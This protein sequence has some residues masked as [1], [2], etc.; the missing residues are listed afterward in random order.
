MSQYSNPLELD[1]MKSIMLGVVILTSVIPCAWANS[2][3]DYEKQLMLRL[4]ADR[5]PGGAVWLGSGRN[6]FLSLYRE[7]TDL[8]SKNAAIILHSMG[9][10]ADWPDLISPLRKHLPETGWTSLSVQ[11]PVLSPEIGIA[12]YGGTFI[13]ANRRIRMAVRY[14][15]DKDYS[16]IVFIGVG[17]GATTAV[18]YLTTSGSAVKALVGI[19][20]QNHDFLKPKYN[21]V[22]NLS[23]IK[24][25]VL[26]IYAGQ[27]GSAVMDSIYDRR[28][29]GSNKENKSYDQKVIQYASQYFPGKETELVN[30]IVRWLDNWFS[31]NEI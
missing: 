26:D 1:V 15:L 19:S 21:L 24:Q 4:V 11:L 7:A 22:E 14:L 30:E 6:T 16:N 23:D 17:F 20:M 9:M 28:L 29:A 27:D 10:H 8:N 2:P 25:P 5:S 3:A 12:E 31:E 13:Q 18:Q